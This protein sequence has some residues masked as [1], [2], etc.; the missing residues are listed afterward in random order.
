MKRIVNFPMISPLKGSNDF[1]ADRFNPGNMFET[2]LPSSL[3]SIWRTCYDSGAAV[4]IENQE[5][6]IDV[7]AIIG[8]QHFEKHRIKKWHR[9]N[10]KLSE[11]DKVELACSGVMARSVRHN[12][13]VR[14]HEAESHV[15]F[16]PEAFTDDI[17]KFHKS[18]LLSFNSEKRVNK[19]KHQAFISLVSEAKDLS[20]DDANTSFS[21][22]ITENL[23]MDSDFFSLTDCM[24]CCFEEIAYTMKHWNQPEQFMYRYL[25]KYQVG[26]VI[27]N[28]GTH[29][30]VSY[31]FLKSTSKIVE[32]G[33]LGPILY[34][35]GDLYVS[36]WCSYDQE[37]IEHYLKAG[38]YSIAIMSEV[39]HSLKLDLID[40]LDNKTFHDYEK[41]SEFWQIS[42]FIFLMYMSKTDSE[43][44]MTSSRYLYMRLLD[45]FKPD[46]YIFVKRFPDVIRSR[47]TSYMM[48][49]LKDIMM[50]YYENPIIRDFSTEG[51]I[52][53]LKSITCDGL[54]S[55]E[56]IID[57]FYYGYTV[58]KEKMTG[59]HSSMAI[60]RKLMK[61]EFVHL[62]MIKS[63][64][65]PLEELEEAKPHQ[66]D[67]LTLKYFLNIFKDIMT[68]RIGDNYKEIIGRNV[69]SNILRST[70]AELGTLKAS[71]GPVDE[72]EF[73]VETKDEYSDLSKKLKAHSKGPRPRAIESLVNLVNDYCEKNNNVS[74]SNL[75]ELIPYCL[76]LLEEGFDSD[77]FSKSQHGGH[78]EIHILQMSARLLQFFIELISRSI[79]SHFPTDT[80]SHPKEKDTMVPVHYRDSNLTFP[81]YSTISK[82]ADAKTWCQNHHTTAFASVLL[83]CTPEDYHPFIIRVM[84]LWTI[85]RVSLPESIAPLFLANRDTISSDPIFNEMRKR[86][87]SGELPFTKPLSSTVQISSGMFQ[88]ILHLTSS[89]YHTMIQEVHR[90]MVISTCKNVY[91]FDVIVSNRQG[92]DDSAMMISFPTG[93]DKKKRRAISYKM[94][95][96]KER[97]SPRLGVISSD[98]TATGITDVV[99]YNSEWYLRQ[100]SVKPTFRWVS[101]CLD[102]PVTETFI[103]EYRIN[104]NV[105]TQVLEGG[106]SLLL[107]SLIELSQAMLHYNLLGMNSSAVFAEAHNKLIETPSPVLGFYPISKDLLAGVCGFDFNLWSLIKNNKKGAGVLSVADLYSW[108]LDYEGQKPKEKA[109]ALEET[110]IKFTKKAKWESIVKRIKL[111]SRDECEELI[112]ED[113]LIIFGSHKTWEDD[114]ISVA[115]KL[116]SP[117]V[118]ASLS[119]RM[120]LIRRQVAS[121]YIMNC[122]CFTVPGEKERRSLLYLWHHANERERIEPNDENM[123]KLFPLHGEYKEL[124]DSIQEEAGGNYALLP[125]I[126]RRS[127]KATITVFEPAI[128]EDEPIMQLCKRKWFNTGMVKYNNTHFNR[129]WIE[130]KSRYVNIKDTLEE[131][132]N[133]TGLSV[134]NLK[135]YLEGIDWKP[136]KIRLTDTNV[137]GSSLSSAITR[138]FWPD[139][140]LIFFGDKHISEKLQV[141]KHELFCLNNSWWAPSD[142]TERMYELIKNADFLDDNNLKR[143]RENFPLWFIRQSLFE[144]DRMKLLEE[145]EVRKG[146]RLGY[147]SPRQ[148]WKSG[149]RYGYGRWIGKVMGVK[150]C[151]EMMDNT[152]LKISCSSLDSHESLAYNIKELISELHLKYPS[153]SSEP[154]IQYTIAGRF[155]HSV[156]RVQSAVPVITDDLL[157]VDLEMIAKSTW[158]LMPTDYSLR[159][160]VK[161]GAD[162][163]TLCACYLG[164]SDYRPEL[165]KEIKENK[166]EDA[167]RSRTRPSEKTWKEFI[168]EYAPSEMSL[169]EEE[170]EIARRTGL[171]NGVINAGKMGRIFVR[172]IEFYTKDLTVDTEA[173][174]NMPGSLNTE[175]LDFIASLNYG[176][177]WDTEDINIDEDLYEGMEDDIADFDINESGMRLDEIDREDLDRMSK[178]YSN[179]ERRDLAMKNVVGISPT[180]PLFDSLI[181]YITLEHPDFTLSEMYSPQ[182]EPRAL[183]YPWNV[184]VSIITGKNYEQFS[185]NLDEQRHYEERIE[186]ITI[187]LASG[188]DRG[189]IDRMSILDDIIG[190]STGIER[191]N[192]ILLKRAEENYI[193]RYNKGQ[194]EFPNKWIDTLNLPRIYFEMEHEFNPDKIRRAYSRLAGPEKYGSQE[195]LDRIELRENIMESE[196]YH[197][198]EKLELLSK[199]ANRR[200]KMIQLEILAWK[201]KTN[202]TLN[203]NGESINIIPILPDAEVT[204]ECIYNK[205]TSALLIFPL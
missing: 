47:F 114:K 133:A 6:V 201:F 93:S 59:V 199:L 140:R 170:Y 41:N 162:E 83:A 185:D 110:R 168:E 98:K 19:P 71:G 17:K 82:S 177:A 11:N 160:I 39:A 100:Q 32:T 65:K 77:L 3:A 38:P 37:H 189:S 188:T 169:R 23:F 29:I 43:E 81:E 7:E 51:G 90:E 69:T 70:F 154:G 106:G 178:L 22:R 68:A 126:L 174:A 159:L 57:S 202:I 94:L 20:G 167:I 10:P 28:T 142:I 128:Y 35:M 46:P 95:D 4:P 14:N 130:L 156:H 24:S 141:L 191:Q 64:G 97:F 18:D 127:N 136:R 186:R 183:K 158:I 102:F 193:E 194:Y 135:Y 203:F 27:Y 2:N 26:M 96:W 184:V 134:L 1:D 53:F 195:K 157:S 123:L 144:S 61:E 197:K 143:N 34:N 16:D 52:P 152:L 54:V 25:R 115:L 187:S 48:Q 129:A 31:S 99:E 121:A 62:D 80:I 73:D 175:E 44:L 92:S 120:R 192:A 21:I 9:F 13:T 139:I 78:R 205:E 87:I 67:S 76:K 132:K 166:L 103:E 91:G 112:E 150:V 113:P 116:Y 105:L 5:K 180:N 12:E 131:T 74:P 176:I 155:C 79:L 172:A 124:Y 60:C 147:F 55:F 56:V 138:I 181:S 72:F 117:G 63:G 15:G 45:E 173:I 36:D 204:T 119:K 84:K 165:I 163:M 179:D 190:N 42:K 125:G 108:E 196:M 85:K 58:S 153:E 164:Q 149:K 111:P 88:G 198:D 109:K 75:F 8:R 118:K 89:L 50:H 104:S 145:L 137:K 33:R 86:F 101:A 107:A 146:G 200:S 182:L 49:S 66:V 122:E 171:F 151:L 161:D 30:F 148:K 40:M